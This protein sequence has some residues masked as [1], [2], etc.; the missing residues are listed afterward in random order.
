[1]RSA[2][3]RVALVRPLGD[4][5]AVVQ[6]ARIH[7]SEDLLETWLIDVLAELDLKRHRL[8]A[9]LDQLQRAA[10]PIPVAAAPAAPSK[11]GISRNSTVAEKIGLFR[12]L[13]AG[14]T[15]VVPLRWENLKTGRSGYSP[16]C[17]NEWVRGVCGKPQVKCGD[18]PNQAFVGASDDVVECH[19]RG[20]DR[21][22]SNRRETGFV[23]GVYPLLF[24]DTCYFLAVDLDKKDWVSDAKA[25]LETCRELD[26]PAAL[27]RSRSGNGGHVWIFFAEAV[28]ASEARPLSRHREL[29]Q[30]ISIV[31]PFSY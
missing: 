27:E 3:H 19:L 7:P 1:M 4:D 30:R 20:E 5:V 28:A 2:N 21:I 22:R 9:R 13:F 11:P 14:R 10:V 29:D 25:F 31:I 12:R 24:D 26:V 23:A 8:V 6:A 17:L 18:C 16:A 15:D